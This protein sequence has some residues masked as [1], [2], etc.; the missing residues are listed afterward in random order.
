MWTL[1]FVPFL[2]GQHQIQPAARF[3]DHWECV[4][5]AKVQ[6]ADLVMVQQQWGRFSCVHGTAVILRRP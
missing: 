3:D 6:N 1:I 5:T 2:I 4:K